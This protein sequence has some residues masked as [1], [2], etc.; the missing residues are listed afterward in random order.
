MN[1]KVRKEVIMANIVKILLL[2]NSFVATATFI[3]IAIKHKDI[4]FITFAIVE[5]VLAIKI[6]AVL[7]EM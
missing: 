2:I 6:Y 4:E 1:E 5:I 3:F 7:L